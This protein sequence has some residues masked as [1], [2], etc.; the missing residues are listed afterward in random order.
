MPFD[1]APPT[2]RIDTPASLLIA[3]GMARIADPKRWCKNP[4]SADAFSGNG[5]TCIGIAL[6]LVGA[7][8]EA[9]HA[10]EAAIVNRGFNVHGL[11]AFNDHPA[12]THADVLALMEEARL[13]AQADA[14]SNDNR[15]PDLAALAEDVRTAATAPVYAAMSGA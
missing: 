5:P 8:S 1:A 9:W 13:A 15:L 2:T 12:T 3:A 10:I 6:Q 7:N 4:D 11:V 14:P